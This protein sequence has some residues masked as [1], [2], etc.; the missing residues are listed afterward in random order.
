MAYKSAYGF[1]IRKGMTADN[2][3]QVGERNA[4]TADDQRAARMGSTKPTAKTPRIGKLRPEA[5]DLTLMGAD[6]VKQRKMKARKGH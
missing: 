2:G 3:N 6:A 4:Q 1:K 5:A